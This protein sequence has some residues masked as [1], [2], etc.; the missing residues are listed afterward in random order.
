[1]SN[2]YIDVARSTDLDTLTALLQELFTIEKDF[3]A[4]PTKQ[5]AGLQK[6][7][8]DTQRARIF[9]AR[10]AEQVIG[11][12]CVQLVISTSQGSYSAWVE[13]VI[14]SHEFRGQGIGKTLL[15]H[16]L[17][18]AKQQGATRAQLVLDG[19]NTAAI[20]FYQQLGWRE[21]QLWVRQYFM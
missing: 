14:V 12:C 18:W 11:L 19:Q 15:E 6:L 21:T 20:Q 1:M 16:A 13:D 4:D 10:Q 17:Q 5:F 7:L 2:F 9:V 3:T 8:A